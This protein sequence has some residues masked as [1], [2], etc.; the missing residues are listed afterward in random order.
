MAKIRLQDTENTYKGIHPTVFKKINNT[1]VSVNAFQTY[2]RWVVISG[3]STSSMLPLQGVYTNVTNL[4]A[5]GSELTYND[6]TN[7]NGSLQSVTYFSINHLYYKYKNDPMKTYGP[8]DIT[9]TKKFLYQTASIFSIPQNK[10]GEAVKPESFIITGSYSLGAIYGGSYYG[11]GSYASLTNLYIE[12]DRYGNLY[13]ASYD[14]SSNI[15]DVMFYEGF[16]EYFDLSRIQIANKNIAFVNGVTTTSGLSGSIGLA[17]EFS[18]SSYM[19]TNIPGRYDRDHDYAISFFINPSDTV[20]TNIITT[21]ASSSLTPQYPFRIEHISGSKLNFIVAGSTTF[22]SQ[23]TSSQLVTNAWSHVV[24]QKTGSNMQIYINGILDATTTS[25]L[26]TVPNGPFTASARFDNADNL[27]IGGFGTDSV[28]AKLD[29]F[30]IYNKGLSATQIG[31][32]AD[33]S[34]GGTLLQTQYCGN[35][36]T[37]QGLAVI[38]SPDYRYNGLIYSPYTA[39]YRSTVTIHELS[40]VTKLDAGDFNVSSNITLTKDDDVTYYNFVTGSA[41][42]PYITTIGLYDNAGQLL[43]IGKLAQ[44]IRKRSDVDMNFLI[45][46]DLDRT[47]S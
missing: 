44:P 21:K 40:V 28:Q 37:K 16:N 31:Y 7:I 47:L 18:A 9:R 35:I 19:H 38:S 30:R 12:S 20:T 10:I 42:A 15:S 11:T 23:V 24:C 2:K 13:D 5:I 27:R 8:T 45:R 46:I 14:T 33:R 41:F 6:A 32:L 43:A 39:S 1:D 29:E 22:K 25:N 17:A 34:E 26:L 36:F 3:S 4:P